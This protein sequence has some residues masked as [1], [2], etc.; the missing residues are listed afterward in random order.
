MSGERRRPG[1]AVPAALLLAI[2]FAAG[3]ARLFHLRFATGGV[4]PPYST[5]RADPLGA[6]AFHDSLAEL[7]LPAVRS[8]RPAPELPAAGATLFLLGASPHGVRWAP[9]ELAEALEGAA[10]AGGRVV[11]CLR[12]GWETGSPRP[13]GEAEPAGDQREE[14]PGEAAPEPSEET[15][16][17]TPG[18]APAE[19]PER[20][21][22]PWSL[23]A[24]LV[25]LGDRWGLS[26][27]ATPLPSRPAPAR[28]AEG[29][30]G[31]PEDFS[32][33]P[34]LPWYSPVWLKDL[35][36]AWRVIYAVEGRPVVAERDFGSGTLVV[37]SDAYLTSNEALWRER[38]PAFLAWLAGSGSPMVF[39]EAHLGVVE[40]PGVAALA[41]RLGLQGGLPALAALFLLVAWRRGSPLGGAW[42]EAP[43]PAASAGGRDA[44]EGLENLLRRSIPREQLLAA[45]HREWE[46]TGAPRG[47]AGDGARRRLREA[48]AEASEGEDPTETYR[49][50]CRALARRHRPTPSGL[51][52]GN[53]PARSGAAAPRQPSRG[54]P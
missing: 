41:R 49:R 38:Q 5:L 12:G 54:T 13:R 2:L 46:R 31:L 44:A 17:E 43:A 42:P 20:P 18:D 6:R 34:E 21:E 29:A 51:S 22:A 11:L 53:V 7:G 3:L 19:H 47:P 25:S 50:L 23:R 52:G 16:P 15:T 8:Y 36:D 9:R 39:A 45:C 40:A 1:L 35:D 28:R 14:D 26:L 24:R 48:L 32:L 4:Y 10:A 27:D 33:P 30:E 37:A